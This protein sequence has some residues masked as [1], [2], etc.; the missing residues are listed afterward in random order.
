MKKIILLWLICWS[1]TAILNAQ[2]AT[3][4]HTAKVIC[5]FE[6]SKD[7]DTATVE[8]WKYNIK[9]PEMRQRSLAIIKNSQVEVKMD[10]LYYP[11]YLSVLYKQKT[12]LNREFYYTNPQLYLV[13]PGDNIR[14]N[15]T[16]DSMVFSG[17][18]A[19]KMQIWYQ[20]ENLKN[21]VLKDYPPRRIHGDYKNE[22][23]DY[24]DES[25]SIKMAF[26]KNT[27]SQVSPISYQ[28]MLTDIFSRD[29]N[30]RLG[31]FGLDTGRDS[32]TT[33]E[34]YHALYSRFCRKFET[35][36]HTENNEILSHSFYY[37]NLLLSKH[38]VDSFAL[39]KKPFNLAVCYEQVKK[40]YTGIM[41]ERLI[42]S[43]LEKYR[44]RSQQSLCL[45]DAVTIVKDPELKALLLKEYLNKL[46]GTPAFNFI[47]TNTAGKTVRL[48]DFKNKV[49]ILDFWFTGCL[50][51][52]EMSTA[53]QP[54]EAVFKENK[55]VVFISISIDTDKGF[56][57]KSL[58]TG[59]YSTP[60]RI[61]LYTNGEGEM[62]GLIRY[63]DIH[64]Y[65]TVMLIDT[66]G[67]LFSSSL[68]N[69][70]AD[71]GEAMIGEIQQVLKQ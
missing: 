43:L 58:S 38:I 60:E 68:P 63:Y 36:A 55:N 15:C 11:V 47:L 22:L 62:N 49:V 23:W 12:F 29:M 46:K 16:K 50:S 18:G 4:S 42:T 35:F 61:N 51:C 65:P 14:I 2:P 57:L 69:P 7:G 33:T 8:I 56:W 6:G 5:H 44:L 13:E 31:D 37:T 19:A 26:L 28:L 20:M 24:Y 17:L 32:G 39:V 70:R 64:S 52:I 34:Y 21:I 66:H 3:T 41:R 54:V 9:T 27:Q 1:L 10:S 48:S 53:L 25:L 40:K 30:A 67:N 59:Y 45:Q 71:S